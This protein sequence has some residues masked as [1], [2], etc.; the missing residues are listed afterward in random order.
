MRLKVVNG[1]LKSDIS[2][3]ADAT[4]GDLIVNRYSESESDGDDDSI[5]DLDERNRALR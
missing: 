1:P 2:E 4:I 5:L 3:E